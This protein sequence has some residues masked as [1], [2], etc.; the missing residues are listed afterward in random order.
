MVVAP[1]K[2][3]L[4][5]MSGVK[6]A[7]QNEQEDKKRMHGKKKSSGSPEQEEEDEPK[8]FE[9]FDSADEEPKES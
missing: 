4:S 6:E 1:I 9:V 3:F 5:S 7:L 2:G 8:T